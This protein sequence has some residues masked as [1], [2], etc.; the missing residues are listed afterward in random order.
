MQAFF[1][2]IGAVGGFVVFYWGFVY[3][4]AFDGGRSDSRKNKPFWWQALQAVLWAP[5]LAF[6]NPFPFFITYLFYM[7]YKLSL[8]KLDNSWLWFF[9]GIAFTFLYIFAKG[10]LLTVT[11]NFHNKTIISR[12]IREEPPTRF[13]KSERD[14]KL[15]LSDSVPVKGNEEATEGDL[16][17]VETH[18]PPHIFDDRELERH[19]RYVADLDLNMLPKKKVSL[20]TGLD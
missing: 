13:Q 10:R 14:E 6:F 20:T 5:F 3:F 8:G 18:K 9:L 15:L 17:D 2:L 7:G 1:F 12:D 16:T 4:Q 11:E 19:R